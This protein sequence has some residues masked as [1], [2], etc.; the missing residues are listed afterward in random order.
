[1]RRRKMRRE[2]SG[3][4]TPRYRTRSPRFTARATSSSVEAAQRHSSRTRRGRPSRNKRGSPRRPDRRAKCAFGTQ[5]TRR[6][7]TPAAPRE[8]ASPRRKAGR[9]VR[10]R[11][12]KPRTSCLRRRPCRSSRRRHHWRCLCPSHPSRRSGVG[13]LRQPRRRLRSHHPRRPHCP[14]GRPEPKPCR[15]P[16]RARRQRPSAANRLRPRRHCLRF[17]GARRTKRP[18]PEARAAG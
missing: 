13:L 8:Q 17:R 10:A 15:L 3:K 14:R 7:S 12:H 4:S 5:H 9:L 16:P 18:R 2:A 1:M 11:R 6:R